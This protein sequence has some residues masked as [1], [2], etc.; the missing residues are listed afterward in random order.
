[1]LPK[2]KWPDYYYNL[3]P[4]LLGTFEQELFDV[5]SRIIEVKPK[6]IVN[7]G[8]AEG[9]YAVGLSRALPETN[10]IAFEL[11]DAARTAS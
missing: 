6:T 8:C 1:M 2:I 3:S 9:Y 7:V 11:I 10:V 4:M 5:I